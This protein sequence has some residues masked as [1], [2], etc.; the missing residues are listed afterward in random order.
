MAVYR[1]GYTVYI[2][3]QNTLVRTEPK[4]KV[5]SW[6]LKPATVRGQLHR[7]PRLD[8]HE[9]W[10]HWIGL[11]K[12]INRYRFFYFFVLILNI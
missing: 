5:I 7:P 12:D 1:T 8:L 9:K 6:E 2:I 10:H 4:F 11:E 3:K